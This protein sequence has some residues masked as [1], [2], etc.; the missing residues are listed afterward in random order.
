MHI[1]CC[2][3]ECNSDSE[4]TALSHASLPVLSLS[5]DTPLA[6]VLGLLE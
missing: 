4:D 2:T 5:R 3:A 1:F 6:H